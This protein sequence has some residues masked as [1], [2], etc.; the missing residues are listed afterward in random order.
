MISIYGN[1]KNPENDFSE[2]ISSAMIL[3]IKT[4]QEHRDAENKR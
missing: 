3:S 1:K 4:K 2:D